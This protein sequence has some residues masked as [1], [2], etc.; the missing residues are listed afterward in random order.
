MNNARFLPILSA[1]VSSSA[2]V[3]MAKRARLVVAWGLVT[4]PLR[5][6]L[7]DLAPGGRLLTG[8]VARYIGRVHRLGPG[9]QL[10][11]FDPVMGVEAEARVGA[12]DA[13]GVYCE[14]GEV[15]RSGYSA[16]PISLLQGLAKAEKPDSVIRDA[17]ALGVS[18]IVFVETERAVAR[19][20]AERGGARHERWKRIAMEAARQSGR[21]NLPSILGPL[22]ITSALTASREDLRVVL[23]PGAPPLLSQ[24]RQWQPE[25]SIALLIGPEGGLSSTEARLAEDAGF[26]PASLGATTLRTELAGVAALGALV[27]LLQFPWR[28]GR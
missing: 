25:Q 24:L 16:H 6:P 22:P 3:E 19:V 17:T 7:E 12:G 1:G 20:S 23:S 5:V 2:R 10:L 14:V 18:Q 8:P 4:K 9:D 27:A 28:D 15:R 11:L 21:G 26:A 13:R